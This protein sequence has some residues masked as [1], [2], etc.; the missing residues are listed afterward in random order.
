M[1]LLTLFLLIF[2]ISSSTFAYLPD[3]YDVFD[4]HRNFQKKVSPQVN[5]NVNSSGRLLSNSIIDQKV[6][7]YRNG[8]WLATGSGLNFWKVSDSSWLSITS[9]ES[10]GN[11][12]VSAVFVN[13]NAIWC[14]TAYDTII[15]GVRYPAGG[16]IGF[17]TDN[18]NNWR[19]Y[20]QPVDSR[21]ETEYR[22]TTTNIQN[23]TYDLAI[24]NHAVWAASFGGGLRKFSF[25]DSTWRVR[26]PDSNPFSALTYLNH[27]VFSVMAET[28]SVLWVGTAAGINRS[29][30]SGQ[31]WTNFR[32]SPADTNTI[33][34]NFVVALHHQFYNNRQ[35]LWASTWRAE[36][37]TEEYGLSVTENNGQS[38]K[39]TL[40]G[41]KIHNLTSKDSVIYAVGPSGLFKS[42][43]FG[44]TWWLFPPISS[45]TQNLVIGDS[46]L[47]SVALGFNKLVVGGPD[48]W[49]VS[50][51]LGGDWS[52]GRAFVSTRDKNQPITYAFPNPFSPRRF[53]LVR[54]QYY[55]DHPTTIQITLYNFAMEKVGTIIPRT[56]RNSGDQQESWNGLLNN[57]TPANGV[58]FY[59]L[60][61]GNQESWGKLII[62]D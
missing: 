8:F 11:G 26:P 28:D 42:V 48:G 9:S 20:S 39:R 40:V 47:Y 37:V 19:W 27:R 44:I 23:L 50:S 29:S 31:S 12:G 60:E 59:R 21:D 62:L 53:P 4:S 6:D 36:G 32:H 55:L 16:G 22:P 54:F 18:G 14:A 1:N 61:Y 52:I 24:T 56:N 3:S 5:S 43:D 13:S 46:E 30:D 41:E 35:L 57:Q 45:N 7:L 25:S 17:S 33:T 15:S 34:G 58:Y 2:L 38:W 10:F 49:A 51:N